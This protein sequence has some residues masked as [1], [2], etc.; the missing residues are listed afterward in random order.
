MYFASHEYEEIFIFQDLVT[1][2]SAANFQRLVERCFN[3]L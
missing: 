3:D 2:T 1:A